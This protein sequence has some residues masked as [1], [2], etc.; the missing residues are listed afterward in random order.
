MQ[1]QEAGVWG[2]ATGLECSTGTACWLA[3]HEPPGPKRHL[4]SLQGH[5]L[6]S[7]T[8]L[9]LHTCANTLL[10]SQPEA[11]RYTSRC[12]NKNWQ[13]TVISGFSGMEVLPI[14]VSQCHGLWGVLYQDRSNILCKCTRAK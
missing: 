10:V 1:G 6:E 4:E 9:V 14:H 11:G 2:A 5:H 13:K 12:P 7:C 3:L 8:S